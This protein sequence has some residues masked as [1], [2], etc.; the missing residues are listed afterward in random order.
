MS[1]KTITLNPGDTLT[2]NVPPS[3]VPPPP[4]PPPPTGGLLPEFF[5]H[6]LMHSAYFT[7]GHFPTIPF[8]SAR[9]WDCRVTWREIETSRGVY[10]W[11]VLDQEIAKLAGKKV[12]YCFGKT[13][14]WASMRPN[15]I[16]P[17]GKNDG[18][19]A[20]PSD[21]DTTNAQW[22]EFITALA[23]RYKGKLSFEGWNEANGTYTGCF[24]TGTIPQLVRM[25]SDAFAIIKGIDPTAMVAGPSVD[26][27]SNQFQW[28]DGYLSAGGG[29]Y[30]DAVCFH[31]YLHDG[32]PD[33][34]PTLTSWLAQFRALMAKHGISAQQLWQTEG[35]WGH[36]TP[37]GIGAGVLTSAQQVAYLMQMYLLLWS[38]GV[39]RSM[40]Y[41]YDNS[42]SGILFD[43]TNGLRPPGAAYGELYNVIVGA[44]ITKPAAQSNGQWSIGFTRSDGTPATYTWT[45]GNK[46][47]LT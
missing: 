10:N 41:S 47:V 23:T 43:G 12:V 22:K 19:A 9:L 34:A 29:K 20:P 7:A 44:T 35:G 17:G 25:Q 30:Q 13:P 31:A 24:W 16:S 18:G 46:P 21:V 32:N 39:S 14:Q 37:G 1:S 28:L 2:V 15:E 11:A 4:P 42:Q 5:G 33:P 3:I 38:A 27:E 6:D 26:G 45:P 8:G 40:W 36:N